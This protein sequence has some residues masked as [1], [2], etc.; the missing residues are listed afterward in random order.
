[1][2]SWRPCSAQYA[3]AAYKANGPSGK[4]PV[5]FASSFFL[6]SANSYQI[7]STRLSSRSPLPLTPARSVLQDIFGYEQFRGPQEAIALHVIGGSDALVLMP[8]G[9]GK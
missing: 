5:K 7:Q 4:N 8:T 2:R 1:M 9:G 3:P 6:I